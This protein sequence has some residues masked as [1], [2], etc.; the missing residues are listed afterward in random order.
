VPPSVA[1]A[2]K[3]PATYDLY[4]RARYQW[5]RRSEQSLRDSV[6]LFEQVVT[7]DPENARAWVGLADTYA[8]MGVY[9]Y[10]PPRLAFPLADSAARHA[11]VLDSSLAAPYATLGYVDTYFRWDWRAAEDTFRRAIELEPTYSVAHQWYSNLLVARGRF[12]EAEWEM[13]RAAELDPLSMIAH[14]GIGWLLIFAGEYDRAIRQLEAS[15]KLD[16]DFTLAHLWLGLAH[17]YAGRPTQAIPCLARMLSL[18]A[19]ETF[20]NVLGLG[21]L[22]RAHAAAGAMDEAQAIL[23]AL[24]EQEERGRYV[25]SFQLGKVLLALGDVPEALTRLERAFDERSHS[26]VFLR[27][28]PQ[29]AALSQ[30]PRYQ[31]IV[32]AVEGP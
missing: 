4:L 15:L 28:D 24:L 22:A 29:L 20:E 3:D 27:V 16:G 25:S 10:L 5:H 12:E 1:R 32:D 14:A 6:P 11:I 17:L 7:R 19:D 23:A 2:A 8:V 26:M 21:A 13:R 18:S 31:R 9:D 30:E